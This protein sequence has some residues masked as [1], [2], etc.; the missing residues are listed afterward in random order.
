MVRP[1]ILLDPR[2]P[3]ATALLTNP[4]LFSSL[5]NGPIR[6]LNSVS[7]VVDSA[8]YMLDNPQLSVCERKAN[9]TCTSASCVLHSEA[10]RLPT[11]VLPRV[12]EGV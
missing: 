1:G 6:L 2:L 5:H 3:R 9:K 12:T 11:T 7:P 8:C 10:H 4:L